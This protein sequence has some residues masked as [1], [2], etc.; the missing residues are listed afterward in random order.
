M[1]L[2]E[3]TGGSSSPDAEALAE[4]LALFGAVAD[5]A[6]G[7]PPQAGPRIASLA[8]A[9]AR[10]AGLPPP[11]CGALYFAAVL[12]NAGTLG[13][14]ALRKGEPLGE[15]AAA[16]ALWDV[17]ADGARTCERIAA[18]PP[19][20]ADIV[21][22]QAEAWDGTGYPDHLRWHGIP[23]AAQI[24]HLAR[25]YAAG[26]PDEA[27]AEI[28]AASGRVFSPEMA[29]A[30]ANWFHANA[31]EVE[32]TAAPLDALDPGAATPDEIFALL[33]ARIDAHNGT[34][35]RW[36]RVGESAI[37]L[38]RLLA[39][40]AAALRALYAAAGLFGIGELRL[41]EPESARFDP[42]SRMGIEARAANALT[43]QNL[44]AAFPSM[45]AAAAVLRSRAEWY[46]GT[47][48][49][50]GLRHEAIPPAAAIL[51][52]CIAH[53]A[54]EEAYRTN[55]GQ[56]RHTP[57]DRLENASGTQFDPH[58]VRALA[59]VVRTHA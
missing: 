39:L 20:T 37:R 49:P 33:A 53:D 17:P 54:L 10:N 28:L 5:H 15:R 3:G 46:D 30:F 40:D 14:A 18:L 9:L 26:E 19:Q 31:G 2:F 42:L 22:W 41:C 16:M 58:V 25:T 50:D 44:A 32:T 6:A 38:G 1:R 21:R 59:K 55:V 24:L 23:Q 43:A 7:D 12:R 35:D 57:L 45:R 34:P 13:N 48:R 52:A 4:L 8:V 47:G 51:G 29:Q 36:T 11:E 27:F 56:N